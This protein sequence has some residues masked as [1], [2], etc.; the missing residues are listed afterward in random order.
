M[1]TLH[2]PMYPL[3]WVRH[4]LTSVMSLQ[5]RTQ[6]VSDFKTLSF[7]SP[8]SLSE[9]ACPKDTQTLSFAEHVDS[10]C[11][12][13]ACNFLGLSVTI[14]LCLSNSRRNYYRLETALYNQLYQ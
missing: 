2:T 11:V 13:E 14:W 6:N 9:P 3:T 10:P 4:K 1:A 7:A 8:V 5:T 12:R